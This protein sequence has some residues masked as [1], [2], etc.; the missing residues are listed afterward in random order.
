[1]PDLWEVLT[2]NQSFL[3]LDRTSQYRVKGWLTKRLK[4]VEEKNDNEF[5]TLFR[6]KLD[7]ELK[8]FDF[9]R[10]KNDLWMMLSG[11]VKKASMLTSKEL[12]ENG[13]LTAMVD[14]LAAQLGRA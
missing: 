11:V 8:R 5:W 14:G 9:E 2:M 1:M 4:P 3:R 7:Q 6:F 12:G 13:D 10:Y